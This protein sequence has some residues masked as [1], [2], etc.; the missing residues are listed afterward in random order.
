MK[1]NREDGYLGGC[2]GI[3]LFFITLVI[4]MLICTREA[5]GQGAAYIILQPVDQGA[6]I[7][8]DYYPL[9]LRDPG[10]QRAGFYH[11]VSYGS[12]GLYNLYGLGQHF[13]FTTGVLI[14]LPYHAPF[15]VGSSAGVSYHYLYGGKVVYLLP[16]K[17]ILR[18]WSFE[19]GMN[20]RMKRL[21]V[22]VSTDILRWEPSVG[23]GIVF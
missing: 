23:V 19:L 20:V 4:L 22:C 10:V 21:A 1:R 17:K 9:K 12:G 14:P 15:R 11:S 3:A 18:S 16:D 5:K 8:F 2:L 7:R 6:G 13:K